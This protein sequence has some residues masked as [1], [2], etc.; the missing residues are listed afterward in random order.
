[1]TLSCAEYFWPDMIRLLEERTWIA[2]GRNVTNGNRVFRDGRTIDFTMNNADRNKAVNDHA[3]TVQHFFIMR[4]Q[5]FLNTVGKS[6]F[7][8]EHYWGRMEF[9]KG[10]GQIH[11]HLLGILS[12]DIK[13]DVQAEL[14]NG[15]GSVSDH[16]NVIALWAEK[17]FG[18]SA[19][20]PS[21]DE[22]KK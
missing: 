11:L 9:A 18:M 6:L 1:M 2:E 4:C 7:G 3:L 10:R 15:N 13:H 5:D 16:A 21:S 17:V 14:N 20:I 12:N 19:S 8:I 22:K